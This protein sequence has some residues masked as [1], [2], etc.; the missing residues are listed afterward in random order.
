[1]ERNPA[2]RKENASLLR[3]RKF[4]PQIIR[5]ALISVHEVISMGVSFR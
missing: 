4:A 1:M 3:F 2:Q 5:F